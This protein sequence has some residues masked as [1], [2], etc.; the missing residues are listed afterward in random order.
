MPAPA[1]V[2]RVALVDD[3]DLFRESLGMNLT[4]EG[5]EVVPFDRG[6]TALDYFAGGGTADLILLDWR[7]PRMDGIETLRQLRARN[8]DIPVIFLTVLSDQI[9]EETALTGGAVDF[10]EKSRSLPIL[11]K[12][13]QLIIQGR[14]PG[15]EEGPGAP[16]AATDA[17]GA[18]GQMF[19]RGP[20]ELKLE[21]ARAFWAGSRID[22][23]LT[24]FNI[25]KLMSTR[26][27]EDVSYRDLYDLVHGK[28]FV[29]GYGPAGYRANVRAFIKRIRHKFRAVDAGFDEIENY[30]GFGYRWSDRHPAE[31]VGGIG[32]RDRA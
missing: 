21:V 6:H 28:D 31:Y 23:T 15:G 5:F 13:M 7:M 3:D 32:G 4:D 27:G 1:P 2:A 20:L 19:R 9:Y 24:E 17:A 25:V 30:P 10:V 26:A 18:G 14:K 8:I 12:R 11:L 22:L 16:S 29:A